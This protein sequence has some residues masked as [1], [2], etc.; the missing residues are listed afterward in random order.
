MT[1]SAFEQLL[2]DLATSL[3]RE[4]SLPLYTFAW[5]L[6]SQDRGLREEDIGV[7]ARRAYDLLTRTR[8]LRL[9]WVT[10]ADPV[11]GQPAAPG[12]PLDFELHPD[13]DLEAPEPFL[14]LVP[15]RVT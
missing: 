7:L 15:V 10:Y 11:H 2:L 13:L 9:E 3:E 12:T 5:S 6:R 14:A 1:A 8:A 4:G